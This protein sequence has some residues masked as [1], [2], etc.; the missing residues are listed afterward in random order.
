M[1]ITAEGRE[2]T[3]AHQ[4]AQLRIAAQAE[5][6]ARALWGRLDVDDLDGSSPYW[7]ASTTLAVQRR[8]RESQ[9]TASAYLNS[10][11]RAE[12]GTPANV[13]LGSAPSTATALQL[14][15]PVRVKR[16]IGTG[17]AA[18]EAY[19]KAV[20]KFGGIVSRQVLMGGRTT[21]ANTASAD[22]RAVGWRRVTDGNPCAFCALLASRGP[23]FKSRTSAAVQ[24]QGL[25]YHGH[26][27]CSAEVV[28]STWTPNPA[29]ESYVAAY[30]KAAAKVHN[31][32]GRTD[33][34]RILSAMRADGFR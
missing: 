11:R 33:L 1:A 18:D 16:L 28:Y 22:R 3:Q 32:I 23:V 24:G 31:E 2:L 27:G 29:E 7:L 34:K 10:Y 4:A 19:E 5:V 30:D 21:I 12:V 20:T 26:C 8:V 6:E 25:R 14:A 17:M 9:S 15:G 13:V